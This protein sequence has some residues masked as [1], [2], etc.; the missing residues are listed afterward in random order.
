MSDRGTLLV[1]GVGNLLM[2]DEGVGVQVAQ[3]LLAGP[4]LPPG[5]ELLDGGTGG[6]TLLEVLTRHPRALLVDACLDGRAAGTV[7]IRRPRHSGHFPTA[8]GAHDI[9]LRA[10]VEAAQLLGQLPRVT[11]VTVSVR[12]PFSM[13]LELSPPVAAAV[14]RVEALVRRWVRRLG[15]LGAQAPPAHA[16]PSWGPVSRA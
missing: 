2:G 14:P 1:M 8:L 3:R 4:P 9:G 15:R 6:F 13:G 16:A 7:R 12:L 5:V 10:M 11:L